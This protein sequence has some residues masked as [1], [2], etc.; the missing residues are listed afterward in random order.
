MKKPGSATDPLWYKDSVLYE[1]HVRAFMDGNNDGIG[2]FPGLIEKLDYLQ[3]LG[4][5]CLWLLPFF[6]SPLKDDGYDI[7][8][9]LNVHPMYGNMDDF[10][11]FLA[12]AHERGLQVMIELVMNHTSDQ[13]P[14]FQR[15]R[16]APKGSWERDYYVWSDTDQK[17]TEARIIFTDTEK[18]NWTWDPVAQAYF[19][20]RFFSHQPDLNYDNPKVVEEML[21]V[22]R[23]W[24]DLGVDA[25]RVDAIPYLVEREG[26]N[27]ENLPETHLIVKKLRQEIDA[28]YE[29][30]AILAEANQWPTDVRPY[31]GDGDECHMTF[32]FP[33]MPRI[34]MALR[35]EDRLPITDIMAQTPEIPDTCQW[36]LFLRNHDELT[37]EMVT[38][39]ERDYMYLAY[40][41]DSRMRIN[42]GIRRRLATLMDNNRRR[43][44]LLNSLLFSFPGTPVVYYG[45]EIGM[46]DNIYLGD[47][48]GVRTPMQWN[49]D[50]N[51]GFSRTTPARLYSPVIMDPIFG[52]EAV[53]VEAQQGDPSSL[54]SWMRNM[55]AL[56][57]LF[58]VFGRGTLE[59]LNPSNRKVLAYLRRYEDQQV[60]CVA[61]LSRFAQ[62]VDL[63]L[64][65]LE[66]AIP[67]EMLGY[68]DFPPIGKQPYRLTLGPY[69]FFWL[70]M[71]G[72]PKY[73]DGAANHSASSPLVADTWESLL[74]GAARSRM[75]SMLLP[76]YLPKQR[77]FG[78][79]TRRIR[80]T[81]IA[82]WMALPDSD[83]VLALVEAQ[84]ETGEPD[85]YLLPLA[86]ASGKDA[87]R[88]RDTLPNSVISSV[89]FHDKPGLLI[90]AVNDDRAGA[91]LLSFIEHAGQV[92]TRHG[93]IR[94][95]PG[96]EFQALRG[97]VATPLAVRRG[98]AEQSNTSLL[99][100]DRLFLKLFRR[101]QPGPNPEC[102]IGKYLTEK[103][104]FDGVPPFAGEVEYVTE[105]GSPATLAVLQGLVANQ[106]DAWKLT[107]EELARYYENCA[108]V[109]FPEDESSTARDLMD[110]AEREPSQFARD[111]VGIAIDSASRLGHRTAQ[112][113]LALASSADEPA[114]A[115][116]PVSTGDLQTLLTALRENAIRV[117]DLLKD[118]VAGLP[119][120]LIDLAGL[121]LSRRRQILD[122]FR[123]SADDDTLGQRIR[124]H[125]DY[126]LGQVLQ[127]KTDY[128]IVDF[129]GE[130]AR[131]ISERRAKLSPLKDVAGMLR[132][133]GYA[134]YSGL[135]AYTARRPED[136]GSLEP[137]ARLWERSVA[138]EFLR[139]Y[140]NRTQGAPFL[141]S[142]EGNFRKLLAI[143]LLDKA[144][145][146][147]SYELNNRPAWVRIP[148]LGILS[149]PMEAGGREW[150]WMPSLNRN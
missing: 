66:G 97:P 40:S 36:A 67:V 34:Y 113:H 131:P 44:E 63:E 126:H 92:Q 41:A 123:L 124:I 149:L 125:G 29:N 23:Y 6:P 18:S 32:H 48:N 65:E 53:N 60:L 58:R 78:G 3:D 30:R 143:Y 74:E 132:S 72:Q 31:F 86:I 118:S 26:T 73:L 45:D 77:W 138:V 133:L 135:S 111:H 82:D 8:D 136:W 1:V 15:A 11:T 91:A 127:V 147:L 12:A 37:L 21:N 9:Y 99:Y 56:R 100:D 105:D 144:L 122:S 108:T 25:L 33:L 94:G 129:E 38:S 117:L 148:L 142:S 141:P 76:E 96:T 19:W 70:E 75:E 57:K 88:V 107:L 84:Y 103:A 10:R 120:E 14:W 80:A 115:P 119:D 146:E 79:K 68:V 13:H 43:I 137:W 71:H 55:I 42:L 49:G 116:E 2:D 150:N 89:V 134:A 104:H 109:A 102:E 93:L 130:P 46:G 85:T 98:S 87:D 7:S 112:L 62:P 51:A 52:Y 83:A 110:L 22:M 50:R 69:G 59:F 106:G 20:H 47:R 139:A 35:Q 27:C 39:D 5:T 140:R 4:V 81:R 64:P 24:L 95:V 16:Q 61:N 54:L 145:Y 17:Y 114:F 121:V 101:Q 90:D 128:V 28:G